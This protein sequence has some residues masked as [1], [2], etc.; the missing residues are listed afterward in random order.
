MED[1]TIKSLQD[2]IKNWVFMRNLLTEFD[3]EER[4]TINSTIDKLQEKIDSINLRNAE[5]SQKGIELVDKIFEQASREIQHHYFK[6]ISS[7]GEDF[8]PDGTTSL[9]SQQLNSL[10][11]SSDFKEWFG[12][13]TSAFKF[14]DFADEFN[15]SKVVSD[16]GEPKLVWHGTGKEFSFFKFSNF[17]AIYFSENKQYSEF[18]ADLQGNRSGYVLPF[19]INIKKPLDL[20]KF[21]INTVDST[22]FWN[23]VFLQTGMNEQQLMV[24]PMFLDKNAPPLPVWVYIRN[25][26]NMLRVLSEKKLFDG[27]IFY[28]FNPNINPSDTARYSSKA[29]II[30]D[31]HDAKLADP[32]RGELLFAS[33]Q[34]FKLKQGGKV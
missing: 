14:K 11:K 20:T 21:G 6:N 1:V 12:D 24:N 33:F 30:F 15:V 5:Q 23:E 17:P 2:E 29:Y 18:F 32:N 27:M 28:E 34:S 10:V 13:W 25:N 19:F 9:L 7:T 8:A 3:I 31:A 22:T 26:E 16:N 4:I